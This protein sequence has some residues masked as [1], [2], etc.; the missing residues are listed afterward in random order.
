M[1]Q[2]IELSTWNSQLLVDLKLKP[3]P[4]WCALIGWKQS[5]QIR[6]SPIYRWLE[7]SRDC[8]KIQKLRCNSIPPS[9]LTCS[10]WWRPVIITLTSVDFR[11]DYLSIEVRSVS[12]IL[13]LVISSGPVF[14]WLVGGQYTVNEG[15]HYQAKSGPSLKTPFK[16]RLSYAFQSNPINSTHYRAMKLISLSITS[17]QIRCDLS[18]TVPTRLRS[19][20][21]DQVTVLNHY[22][23]NSCLLR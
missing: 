13:L 18:Q 8:K 2:L 22:Q 3:S 1:I 14:R 23:M 7:S 17:S 10:G 15:S 19:L 6:Q 4:R 12:C 21:I 11:T 9:Y 5:Y 16:I 20:N